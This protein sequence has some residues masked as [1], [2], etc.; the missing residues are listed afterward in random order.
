MILI[1]EARWPAHGTVF[2]HLVSDASYAELIDFARSAGLHPR[3]FDHGHYDVALR[4]HDELVAAGATRVESTELVRRLRASGL[5]VRRHDRTPTVRHAVAHLRR[6]WHGLLPAAFA[7]GDELLARWTAEGRHYHDARHLAQL[8]DAL[9][10]LGERGRPARLAAWFHDAVYTGRPGDEEA[11]AVLAEAS[12]VGVVGAA[13]ASEVGRL[14]RLTERH[15][16]DPSDA[17]GAALVDA[18]LSVLGLHPARYL[19]YVRDVRLDYAHV[20]DDGFRDGR[21]AVLDELLGR[22]RLFTTDAARGRWE[23]PARANL[24]AERAHLGSA[25][26]L[27]SLE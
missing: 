17:A 1:D 2:G 3:A 19:V 13:E 16:P 5:R 26:V 21:L 15:D 10:A 11:S 27:F 6:E 25:G 12:L 24:S 23:D 7:L 18:D 22:P 8:L 20:A 14:V 9:D 4:R